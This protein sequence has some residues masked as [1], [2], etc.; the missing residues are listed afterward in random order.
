MEGTPPPSRPAPHTVYDPR[1]CEPLRNTITPPCQPTPPGRHTLKNPNYT[2]ALALAQ[3]GWN[4]SETARRINHRAEQTGQRG[5]AVD[6]SRVS[7]WIRHGEKPRHPVPELL[8]TLLTEHLTQPY[9]PRLLGIAADH[10]LHISIGETQHHTLQA[11]AAAANMPAE[12]YARALLHTA[13]S[14]T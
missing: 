4:N 7:R 13:L 1:C 9:T 10:S 11:K 3:A 12:D 2:L 6:R 14:D 5:I 8:A